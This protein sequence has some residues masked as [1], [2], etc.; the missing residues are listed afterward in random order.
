MSLGNV[1]LDRTFEQPQPDP[2]QGIKRIIGI[3]QS[4]V[5]SSG[6]AVQQINQVVRRFG[7]STLEA[8]LNAEEKTQLIGAFNALKAFVSTVAPSVTTEDLA[9]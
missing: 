6:D 1:L 7:R 5:R 8:E 9:E 2:Q 4:Q 3:I